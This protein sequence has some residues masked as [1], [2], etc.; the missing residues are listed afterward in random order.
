MRVPAF[1]KINLS[2]RVL[3]TRPDGYHELR[4]IFQSIELHDTLTIQRARGEFR[5]SCD[6]PRCPVDSTNLVWQAAEAA[7][8]AAGR[9][10]APRNISVAITKRIPLQAGLGGGSSDGV[11]A[12]RA[13]GRMWRVDDLKLREIAGSL[14]ADLPYFFEGGTVL[15]L[16]RGDVLFPLGDHGARWV[17][18]AVPRLGIRTK[19][20]FAWWDED[21]R[22]PVRMRGMQ[23]PHDDLRNELEGPVVA[24]HPEVGRL[25]T[26]LERLGAERAAMTGSGSTV[27]GLF[28]ARA[29]ASRALSALAT[30]EQEAIAVA[31]LTRTLNRQAYRRLAGK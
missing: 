9:A 20:A 10:G 4:T 13:F 12:L 19:D 11:A 8:K 22:Q 21:A 7:W 1:A 14:G 16:E 23:E 28:K 26:G 31:K 18:L 27:F 15:G 30:A 6:D 5:L 24:R 17:V 25:V 29:T 2:L 3:G